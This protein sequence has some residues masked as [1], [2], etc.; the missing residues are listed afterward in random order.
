MTHKPSLRV[1]PTA[2]WKSDESETSKAMNPGFNFAL[3]AVVAGS[4]F[5]MDAISPEWAE[6]GRSGGRMGGS[7]FRSAPRGAPRGMG[8]QSRQAPSPQAMRG[9]MGYGSFMPFPMF[10]PFGFSPFGF[11]FGMGG[12]G[13]IFQIFALLWIVNFVSSLLASAQQHPPGND[14]DDM[15]PR[16]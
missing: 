4:V 15:P 14:D 1:A 7:S 12:F 9:G 10:S 11:G 5:T 16:Y 6:A 2:A 13:F 3:A 8:G